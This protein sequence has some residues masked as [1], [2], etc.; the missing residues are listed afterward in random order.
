M[1]ASELKSAA[2]PVKSPPLGKRLSNG[3]LNTPRHVSTSALD[4]A[5][6]QSRAG[7]TVLDV[8]QP[9]P[10]SPNSPNSPNTAK[11]NVVN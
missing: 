4:D 9:H 10:N 11:I 3:S 5:W 7:G 6:G 2:G 1:I 8:D